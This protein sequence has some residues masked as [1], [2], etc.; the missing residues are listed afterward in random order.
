[1]MEKTIQWIKKN[2]FNIMRIFLISILL[3]LNLNTVASANDLI[4]FVESAYKN[5]P[6]LKAER[7]NLKAIKENINISKS[8]FLP[9]VTVSGTLDSSESTDRTD[10]SGASLSDLSNDTS[11]QSVSVDQKIF[12]GFEGYNSLKKSKLEVEQANYELKDIEQEII[13]KSAVVYY[14]LIYK[15]KSEEFN[16]ANLS[17][18]E[19]QV[20]SDRSRLQRGEISLTDLSQS[21]SSLAGANASFIAAGNELLTAKT[22]FERI[23]RI[24]VP[25]NI[26]GRSDLNITLPNNLND[27][28]KKAEKNNPKLMIA[29]LDYQITERE[30]GIERAKLSPS[31]SINYTK[32]KSEDYSSTVDETDKESV[33]ATITWPI[34]KG[35]ENYSSFKKAKF[36]KNK[37]NLILEDTFNE[38]KSD[39]A[40]AWSLYQSTKSVL[41]STQAQVNA[42]EIANE[43]ITLEYESGNTRTTLEVIQSRS[44]LLNARISNAKAE[45]DF[46][47]SKF[48]LLAVLGELTLENI[49]KS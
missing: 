45:R 9:S 32:S 46:V 37:S 27:A 39:T 24:S 38:V 18:L 11:T 23:T 30:V 7:E 19:R 3:S 49:K 17:L 20:E 13:L 26:N 34:I 12:Q 41:R 47:I 44:L 42:A 28:L 40:N 6:K 16:L 5:N 25:E 8:E 36:K 48:E 33:K 1:M 14:D 21:E 15:T 43:G 2:K 10:H 29:Q 31:A 4:F 35:G 22:N